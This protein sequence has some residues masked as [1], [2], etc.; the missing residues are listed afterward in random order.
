MT[1]LVRRTF[2]LPVVRVDLLGAGVAVV[3][4]A[5]LLLNDRLDPLV[6]V[7]L[8]LFLAF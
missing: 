7:L 3:L 6:V 8:Q 5:L 4:F 2:A 1:E